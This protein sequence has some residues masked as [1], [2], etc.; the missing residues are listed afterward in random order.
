M[1]ALITVTAARAQTTAPAP[2]AGGRVVSEIV[3]TAERR[4]TDIQK[5]P[6]AITA[7]PA[8]T[9]DKSFVTDVAQLN[10]QVPSFQSTQTSGFENI[11]TIRGIGSETPENDLTTVTGVSLFEDGV[12]LINTIALSQT[13]FDVDHIEV[14][15]GPQGALYGQSSIGG[16]INILTRQPQLGQFGA[17]GDFSIGNYDL[18]RVRGWVNLPVG[19]TFALRLSAQHFEHEGFTHDFA[20]PGFREDD[21]NNSE[22]KAAMTWKPVSNFTGTLTGEWYDQNEHGQA[23]KNVLDPEPSPWQIYQDYPSRNVLRNQLYHLNLE[24]DAPWFEVR[25]VTAYQGLNSI[26]QEDSS[27]SAVSLIHAYD[28][29]AGWNTIGHS[30]TEEFDILSKPG[31][32]V[33]WVVGAFFLSASSTQFVAEFEG[34]GVNTPPVIN[35]LPDI[36]TNPPG[37]LAY[38]NLSFVHRKADDGFVQA[39]WHVLPRLNITGGVRYNHDEYSDDSHN[40]SAFGKSVVD[41]SA[42]DDVWTWRADVD[43]DLT[44]DNL[45]YASVARG[46]KPAGVNGS[47]G[48]VVVP[49][50][51]QNETNTAFEIGSKNDFLD[52]TL[53][54]NIDGFY[55]LYKNMQYIETDPVP[56]DAGIANIPNIHIYGIEAE[57]S[58]NGLDNHLHLNGQ[59]AWERGHVVGDTFT[60]DSTV[61]N[62]I[63]SQPYPSPCAF[64]VPPNYGGPYN[65]PP[66]W[67]LVIAAAKDIK[68]NTPPAMPQWSGEA[69]ASYDIDTR[70]GVLTPR[71]QYI[72]RGN[73]WARLFNE[74]SLDYIPSYGVWNLYAEFRP[75]GSKVTLSVAAT[76]VGNTA[77]INSQYT[78]PYGTGTTSRQY[79]APRQVIFTV[80]AEF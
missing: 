55:Y 77:G 39:T 42:T 35:I 25:S 62:P 19:D 7:L 71:V 72:Y 60:I 40:F 49:P 44:P 69:D 68:G 57:G 24:Y 3:V 11:V 41:H 27:R 18:R 1:L 52:H 66:C 70:W 37:N 12:Y 51:F 23:Q 2:A 38:G 76:N 14:L 29:V 63:E 65:N 34:F 58:Y 64:G 47:Y 43:Y 15:R 61:A 32:P 48:Q 78:D 13:L 45:L 20:I 53:R 31:G 54:F 59:V 6:V 50:I 30:W 26:L 56:F 4:A 67:A 80:V 46:Y 10:G 5:T 79:I 21:A 73:M 9:L 36:A 33:D 75:A 8:Q 28:D 16:V 17:A 74:P 22:F